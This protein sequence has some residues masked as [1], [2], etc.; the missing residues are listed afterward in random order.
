M[1]VMGFFEGKDSSGTSLTFPSGQALGTDPLATYLAPAVLQFIQEGG[2]LGTT[3][4]SQ[5][6]I[7]PTE[8]L[9]AISF[10]GTTIISFQDTPN[11]NTPDIPLPFIQFTSASNSYLETA[12]TISIPVTLSF[13]SSSNVTVGY[14]ISGGSA[15]QGSDYT[16]LPGTLT[17]APGETTKNLT[18]ITILTDLVHPESNETI[19]ITLSSPINGTLGLVSSFTVNIQNVVPPSL[20]YPTTDIILVKDQDLTFTPTY[21]NITI[22]S[23]SMS[24]IPSGLSIDNTTCAITGTPDSTQESVPSTV[25]VNGGNLP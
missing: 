5:I 23:C 16:F 22:T 21:S 6:S 7:N 24:P 1:L 9:S 2:S 17:F 8:L 18:A 4:S 14:F 3:A 15:T 11:I 25:T 13:S 19:V 12:G 20:T 10:Q